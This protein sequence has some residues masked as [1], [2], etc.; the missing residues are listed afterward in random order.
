MGIAERVATRYLSSS[1]KTADSPNNRMKDSKQWM[2]SSLAEVHKTEM[3][4]RGLVSEL[5]LIAHSDH[6]AGKQ[7]DHAKKM[8]SEVSDIEKR[9]K[10]VIEQ[11]ERF[12]HEFR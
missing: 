5:G 6:T 11:L 1:E 2:E 8:L 7:L 10:A 12:V 9:S 4:L 3:M